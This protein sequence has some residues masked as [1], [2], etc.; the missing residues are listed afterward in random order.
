MTPEQIDKLWNRA[1]A[2][3]VAAG[4]E[5]TRYRFAA[6]VEAAAVRRCAKTIEGYLRQ[7]S[8]ACAHYTPKDHPAFAYHLT[9][10]AIAE[11]IK[12]AI[13]AEF[14]GAFE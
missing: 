10:V 4:E 2:E 11:D 14:P 3:S 7:H 12:Q 8:A 9:R 13:K 6:M 5:F 1:L